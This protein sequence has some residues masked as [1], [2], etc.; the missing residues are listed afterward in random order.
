MRS[1]P[2]LDESNTDR[3][4]PSR[5][6]TLHRKNEFLT[7]QATTPRHHSCSSSTACPQIHESIYEGRHSIENDPSTS[8]DKRNQWDDKAAEAD[9]EGRG[10]QEGNNEK[11][12]L[13]RPTKKRC[14]SAAR[15]KLPLERHVK[16]HRYSSPLSCDEETETEPESD[17]S[18]YASELCR[19]SNLRPPSSSSLSIGREREPS[20]DDA[21]EGANRRSKRLSRTAVVYEQ[22]CWEGEIMQERDVRQERG[23]PRK[24]YL[25]R[26]KDSWVDGARLA[27]PELLRNWRET[28]MSSKRKC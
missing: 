26:W 24:Q 15:K 9:N 2:Q 25:V 1:A 7:P 20:A 21:L 5:S 23:R 19:T 6:S 14:R 10:L 17:T 11:S 22:Q 16:R 18:S 8:G 4:S 27:A 28:K 13:L 12:A 3:S